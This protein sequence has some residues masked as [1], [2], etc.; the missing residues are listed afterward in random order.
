VEDRLMEAVAAADV[1]VLVQNH[2]DYDVDRLAA[3]AS[4]F[5][6]T[7]GATTLPSVTRL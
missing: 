5:F 7:R 1:T 2:S 6:D 4:R 3:S